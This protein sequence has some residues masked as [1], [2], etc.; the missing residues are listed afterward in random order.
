MKARSHLWP[1]MAAGT[2]C[3][4]SASAAFT[5]AATA[6]ASASGPILQNRWR[7][8]HPTVGSS[9]TVMAEGYR[10]SR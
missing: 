2:T 5:A 9:G 3:T 6:S 10:P 4:S 8:P 7:T 1:S